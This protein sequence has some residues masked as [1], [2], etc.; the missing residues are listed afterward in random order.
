MTLLIYCIF[1]SGSVP[2]DLSLAGV[3]DQPVFPVECGGLA[4]AVSMFC[5]QGANPDFAGLLVYEKVIGFLHRSS[6]TG[7]VV[8]MRFGNLADGELQVRRNLTERSGEYGTLLREVAGCEEMGIRLLLPSP[9]VSACRTDAGP[10]PENGAGRRGSF[11][12][13]T[14]LADR[15]LHYAEREGLTRERDRLIE[16]CHS[17]FSGL[18]AKWGT[19]SRTVRDP[20]TRQL[21]T[22]LSL[23][24]LVP[25]SNLPSFRRKFRKI[26]PD[27]PGRVLLSGPWPPYNFVL[28]DS[29]KTRFF[30]A[31]S[32]KPVNR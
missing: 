23:F 12:G 10:M 8:P 13:T 6:A 19:E 32:E 14:Y 16:K 30:A 9:P 27:I 21:Q 26:H 31:S 24:F 4:A 7:G 29:S 3:A 25:R 15:R 11:A 5:K 18:F 20:Q 2:P 22:L 1:R 17:A 28:S